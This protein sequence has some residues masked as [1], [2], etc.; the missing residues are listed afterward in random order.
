VTDIV[1]VSVGRTCEASE[2]DLA[3]TMVQSMAEAAAPCWVWE[4][5]FA[6]RGVL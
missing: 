3:V 2:K 1:T 5:S 6:N 4:V